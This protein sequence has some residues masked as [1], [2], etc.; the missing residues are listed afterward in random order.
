MIDYVAARRYYA[1]AAGKQHPLGLCNLAAM[2]YHGW[3]GSID[4]EH[5]FTLYQR[6]AEKDNVDAWRNLA[7]MY[8][9]GHGTTKVRT[10]A[11]FA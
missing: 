10:S 1:I 5:A 6:A 8:Q 3:G 11:Y 4:Y 7:H 9:M 2:S